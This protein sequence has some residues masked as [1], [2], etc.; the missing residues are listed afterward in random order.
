MTQS[1]TKSAILP[2]GKLS[3]RPRFSGSVPVTAI[4]SL[5]H[6]NADAALTYAFH[7]PVPFYPQIPMRNPGEYMIPQALESFPGVEFDKEGTAHL[8]RA[9]FRRCREDLKELVDDIIAARN[10]WIFP[11]EHFSCYAPFLYELGER[12]VSW[13]KTQIT[14]PLT[15]QWVMSGS[16]KIDP[17]IGPLVTKLI[18]AKTLT[19]VRDIQSK[20]TQPVIFL[21]EPGL[22]AFKGNDPLHR[23]ALQD[24]KILVMALQKQGAIVGLHCCSNTDWPHVLAMGLDLLSFDVELS[25]KSLLSHRAAI[26]DYL[27]HGGRFSLGLVPTQVDPKELSAEGLVSRLRQD[28]VSYTSTEVAQVILK[29]CWLTP[30]CGLAMKSVEHT[31][32]VLTRLREAAAVLESI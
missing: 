7:Y 11:P 28:V 18:L 22:F 8:D 20:G 5:P 31:V 3:A 15:T 26:E 25:L 19:M 10:H 4:G 16:E 13:A 30:A 2:A 21:D 14:G 27:G 32:S 24:L 17:E 9:A 1:E 12:K 29:D 6:H 23:V